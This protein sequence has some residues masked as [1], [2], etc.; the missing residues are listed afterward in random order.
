LID[1]GG[2]KDG[3]YAGL[4]ALQNRYA[5]VGVKCSDGS[6][7]LVMVAKEGS[8]PSEIANIPLD[9]DK[10]FLRMECEFKEKADRVA[11]GYSYDGNT[12]HSIGRSHQLRYDLVH[13]MGC[14]F[15]LF[16]FATKTAGGHVDFDFFHV[17]NWLMFRDD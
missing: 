6:K 13:F 7:S 2:M 11:F 1:V 8:E 17:G 9:R 10:V 15:G 14:R 3:D 4:I 5:F 12:W 16:N